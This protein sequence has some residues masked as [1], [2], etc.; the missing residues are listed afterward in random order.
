LRDLLER[1]YARVGEYD[2]TR[3][4]WTISYLG[5]AQIARVESG[6]IETLGRASS[7]E[8]ILGAAPGRSPLTSAKTVWNRPA[9]RAGEYGTSLNR[10]VIPGRAFPYPKSVYAVE[11][12]LRIAV[13]DKPNA[14]VLDFFA[15]SGTTAHALLRLNRQ[16][17]GSRTS[18]SVTNNEVAVDEQRRLR[19]DDFRPGDEEW[20]RWGICDYITKPRIVAAITGSTPEGASI[21]GDYRFTDEFPMSDGFEENFESFT[22]TYESAMRVSNHREFLRI[23]PFLW[24]R[25]GSRGRRIDDISTG[26]DVA[27]A[28]GVIA[29]LDLSEQFIKTVEAQDGLTHAFIV[30][31]EDRLFEALVRQLPDHVE[32]VRLYSSYLRNFEIEASRA[33]R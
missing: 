25:A 7:G 8:V 22:L 10:L 12:T 1:G 27:E 2:Q 29:N 26:W 23:A 18:I 24:L 15:G 32:P 4:Q 21:A 20:E 17:G 11:D 13:K 30:T 19:R 28:Y 31:D 9:H 14:I 16:D 3:D 6:E 33:A 5:R